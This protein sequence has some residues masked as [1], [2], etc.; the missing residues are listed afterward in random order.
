M[1]DLP[2][3]ELAAQL[4]AGYGKNVPIAIL[5]RLGLPGEEVVT[6][7]L[8]EIVEKVAGRDFFNLSGA[9]RR[10]SLTLVIAGETLTATVDGKWWDWRREHVW[11][12]RN[13]GER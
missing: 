12:F 3:P 5:H 6:G 9:A 2:L 1:N 4:K 10:P 11:K 7:T 13:G 8:D